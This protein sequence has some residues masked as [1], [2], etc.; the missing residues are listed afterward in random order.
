MSHIFWGWPGS[1]SRGRSGPSF[2]CLSRPRIASE[3]SLQEVGPHSSA[4]TY[5]APDPSP[6]SCLFLPG[7]G[8]ERAQAHLVSTS[9]STSSRGMSNCLL[10]PQA[11]HLR[12]PQGS[13]SMSLRLSS[14]RVGP[15]SLHL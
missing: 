6:P 15:G 10:G 1:G 2:D 8:P 9:A 4:L 13:V 7:L 3:P 14:S 11:S 12:F 5:E